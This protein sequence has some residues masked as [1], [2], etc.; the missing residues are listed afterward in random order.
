VANRY[1]LL[2]ALYGRLRSF[3]ETSHHLVV[4][5]VDAVLTEDEVAGASVER[6]EAVTQLVDSLKATYPDA[7]KLNIKID[8][9]WRESSTYD[10]EDELVPVVN[11]NIER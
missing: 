3:F 9:E 2:G 7:K 6:L 4:H 8:F 10:Q 5:E 11:I 1:G